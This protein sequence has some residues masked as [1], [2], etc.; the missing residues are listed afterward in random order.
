[1]YGII[2]A[3]AIIFSMIFIIIF[4]ASRADVHTY[5]CKKSEA[6]AILDGLSDDCIIQIL[7]GGKTYEHKRAG[8]SGR[9]NL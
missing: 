3:I 1:M 4:K 2:F 5:Y 8:N 6:N 7:I 9:R